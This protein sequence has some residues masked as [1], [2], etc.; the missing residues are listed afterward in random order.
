MG[1]GNSGIAFQPESFKGS[2]Y[3]ALR[4]GACLQAHDRILRSACRRRAA[5]AR[6]R[7][8]RSIAGFRFPI[9]P[10]ET[11]SCWPFSRQN[12][13]SAGFF[14]S[15]FENCKGAT[16]VSIVMAVPA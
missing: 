16:G 5:C 13:H 11:G 12:Q 1:F 7:R 10:E 8:A 4:Q 14:G 9:S 15:V 2:G 3:T 6:A